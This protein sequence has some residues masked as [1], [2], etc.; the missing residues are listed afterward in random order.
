M[1]EK[2]STVRNGPKGAIFAILQKNNIYRDYE[3]RI[4]QSMQQIS[5]HQLQL[6]LRILEIL[7]G[8]LTIIYALYNVQEMCKKYLI[9]FSNASGTDSSGI[10]EYSK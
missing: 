9:S 5:T 6:L 8:F 1:S 10:I 2:V 4:Q 3:K 7:A